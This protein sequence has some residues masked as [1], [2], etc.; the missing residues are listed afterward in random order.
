[1]PEFGSELPRVH[2][3]QKKNLVLIFL[4]RLSSRGVW[5]FKNCTGY[6]D[7]FKLDGYT[8]HHPKG[9]KSFQKRKFSTQ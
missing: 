9:D 1:M 5:K 2:W 7:F 8:P 6:V 4:L 3:D